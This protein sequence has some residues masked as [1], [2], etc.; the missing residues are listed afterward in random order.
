MR[1]AKIIIAVLAGCASSS[2]GVNGVRFANAPPVRAVNDRVDAPPPAPREF[3]R[4]LY[5]YD[6]SVHRPIT[7]A[8]ELQGNPR[9]LGVN[10]MDEV[11]DSTWFTNR[12]GVREIDPAELR[13]LPDSIGSPEPHLPW[14]IESTKVGGQSLGYIMRDA[15]GE[16]WLLKFD[17]P[18]FPEME[19]AAHVIVSRLLWAT[20]YHVTEDHIVYFRPAD[21]AVAAN[22]ISKD[23]FG[24]ESP[25]ER[26]EVTAKLAK[27]ERTSDGKLRALASRMLPGKSLG[28]HAGEGVREDDPNDRIPHERRRDLRGSHTVFAWLDHE[29]IQEGN[30]LDMYVENG[31]GRGYVKHY[32]ID[33][34]K[35]LGVMSA[36][37]GNLRRSEEY[38]LDVPEMLNS[39]LTVGTHQRG[40]EARDGA[41]LRGV[42]V[43]DARTFNP[44]RWKPTTPSY[45][46][47]LT[48]D[49]FDKFWGAKLVMRFTPEQIRAAVEAGRLSDPRATQYLVD[50]LITRQRKLGAY[51]FSRVAPLDGFAM[52][53]D[54]L[55]FDDL[56]LVHTMVLP[57]TRTRYALTSHDASGRPLARAITSAPGQGGR[58]CAK[59]PLVATGDGYTIV[60]VRIDRPSYKGATYVHVARDPRTRAP[61]V[62][63]IWR[64]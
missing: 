44:G 55:C 29:D 27:L 50:T 14:T 46:P 60:E 15:R 5:H 51:W 62:I 40:W 47:F 58:T 22:A 7:R 11:P 6:G 8:M 52:E 2:S 17:N 45:V 30:Y 36:I 59:A 23:V 25:L 13:D 48:A 12:I 34:G 39:F 24:N 35:S 9:A 16:Q 21:I 10:S 38:Y 4:F 28:G 26:E 31:G 54:A 32:F 42:G 53:Q 33:Y 49:R 64:P 18:K 61:R 56:V 19:T 3:V 37:S 63:G 20:G 1:G 41:T 43:F 57:G